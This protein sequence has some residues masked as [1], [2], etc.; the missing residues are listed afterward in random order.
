MIRPSV[1]P[2]SVTGAVSTLGVV[3]MQGGQG[4]SAQGQGSLTQQQ[5][6][7]MHIMAALQQSTSGNM[8]HTPDLD[9]IQVHSP[10]CAEPWHNLIFICLGSIL[11]ILW[12][13]CVW[14][15]LDVP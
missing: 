15:R 8:G 7:L 12:L 3:V 5:G 6:A 2:H 9:P 10:A 13:F 1:P 14:C 11:T 4:Q